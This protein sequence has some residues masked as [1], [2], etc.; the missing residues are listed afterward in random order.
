MGGLAA[1][2]GQAEIA[3]APRAHIPADL[4]V[5]ADMPLA[6]RLPAQAAVS[7][8]LRFS[9][10]AATLRAAAQAAQPGVASGAPPHT[11]PAVTPLRTAARS[12]QA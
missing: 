4:G 7:D 8:R 1:C 10:P 5:P 3:S 11:P 12:A 6:Y 2:H 9:R